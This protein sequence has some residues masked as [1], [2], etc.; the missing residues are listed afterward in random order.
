MEDRPGM[1]VRRLIESDAESLWQLRRT[2]LES[3][4]GSFAES[5]NEL[6]QT[7]LDTYAERLRDGGADNFVYGAFDN[8]TMIGM[9]AFYREP[10]EKRH[11]KGWVWG[12]FVA[13]KY[14]GHGVGKQLL[15]AVLND[16][17]ALPDL[18]CILLTV[19]TSQKAARRL[20]RTCGFASFGVEPRALRVNGKYVDE[21]HMVLDLLTINRPAPRP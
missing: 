19:A 1:E 21:E 7:G 13:E 6:M 2:A 12:M 18:K 20:Y 15:T 14:R 16:A 8:G 10:Y 9:A 3:E 4:A 5:L 11:H 17:K